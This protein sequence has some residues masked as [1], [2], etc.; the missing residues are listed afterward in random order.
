[1]PFT[2]IISF[3]VVFA[4]MMVAISVGLKYFDARR[5]KQ[6]VD[7]LHT[8]SG[9]TVVSVSNLLKDLENEQPTG[10]KRL[11]SSVQFSQHAG[12]LIQQAGLSWSPQRLLAAMGLMMVPGFIIGLMVPFLFNAPTTAVDGSA[13]A[14]ATSRSSASSGK[15]ISSSTKKR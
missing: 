15:T 8:A 13:S 9:E 5:K 3:V 7:M 14:V 1:M 6:V 11:L 4:I 2:V 10:L 12:E